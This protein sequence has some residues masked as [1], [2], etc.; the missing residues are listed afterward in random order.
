MLEAKKESRDST[1]ENVRESLQANRD[2]ITNP[3]PAE[4]DD[5]I[6]PKVK[7]TPKKYTRKSPTVM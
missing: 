1:Y 4:D 2:R 7:Y 3:T 5:E 6:T